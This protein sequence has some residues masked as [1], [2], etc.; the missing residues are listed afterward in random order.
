[1]KIKYKEKW[2]GCHAGA[3]MDLG[4]T[5]A[6]YDKVAKQMF[7]NEEGASTRVIAIGAR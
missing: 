3:S 6:F 7:I 5:V 4:K 2:A 1:M